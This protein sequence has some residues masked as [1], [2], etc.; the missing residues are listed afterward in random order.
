MW[1]RFFQNNLKKNVWHKY[2]HS[3]YHRQLISQ[4]GLNEFSTYT[5]A[6]SRDRRSLTESRQHWILQKICRYHHGDI[7]GWTPIEHI[8]QL[9]FSSYTRSSSPED[10]KRR[11]GQGYIYS[12][13]RNW[14]HIVSQ[15]LISW[16]GSIPCQWRH[17]T[18]F[19]SFVSIIKWSR[20]GKLYSTWFLKV[21]SSPSD[22]YIFPIIKNPLTN[23]GMFVYSSFRAQ[24][25]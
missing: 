20:T 12:L 1:G 10:L 5:R 15:L 11:G 22:I 13:T 2:L 14:E 8:S 7:L 16:L 19:P 23:Y 17:T 3:W 9:T 4:T 6:G 21:K 18:K 24:F 25:I